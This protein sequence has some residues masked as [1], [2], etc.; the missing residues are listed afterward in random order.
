MGRIKHFTDLEV[1]RRAHKLFLDLLD[2]ISGFPKNEVARILISQMVR[3][4]SSISSNIAE[5]FNA[6]STKQY[7]NYLDISKRT[8]AESEN[9]Y[10]KIKDAGVLKKDIADKRISECVEISKMLQGL[11]NSL[12]KNPRI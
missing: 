2:D 10:Y 9:W 5:G 3:S 1:W 8:T 11:I 6:R 12:S 7:L 4:V